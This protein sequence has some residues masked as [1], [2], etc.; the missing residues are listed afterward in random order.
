[1]KKLLLQMMTK[2]IA[3][4]CLCCWFAFAQTASLLAAEIFPNLDGAALE[5]AIANEYRPER[6]LG[7]RR[8]RDILYTQIDN[9]DGIVTGI[10][11][12]YQAAITPDS[13]SPRNDAT[14]QNINAEHIYPQSK[15]AKGQAKSDLHSLFASRD[16]VNSAR[17]NSPF[18]EINDALTQK[19]F[20]NEQELR[21]IP[22]ELIN[23]YS[24][25]LNN[26][27]FEPREN[28]KG[29]VARAMFYFYTVYR[30]QAD[31]EDPNYFPPQ[32]TT[33]CQW[34][35][36]DP[37]NSQEQERSRR[38]AEFQ[39]NENPFVLDSSL[40]QRTYCREP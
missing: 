14:A 39:G 19:W 32:Q 8:G 38:V 37:I 36:D 7:Y 18:A 5:A 13:E 15:G 29:D 26:Q 23:E 28:K 2:T 11:T 10:Y 33:L 40:A 4:F 16:R 22:T 17:S 21:S 9:Q 3:I 27:L 20:R 12:G 6:S 24:E 35:I 31:E 30:F 25:S 1:M 34:N